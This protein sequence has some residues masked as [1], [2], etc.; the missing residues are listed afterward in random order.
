MAGTQDVDET[1]GLPK[2]VLEQ[3]KTAEAMQA[4]IL[5]NTGKETP[6]PAVAT[7]PTPAIPAEGVAPATPPVVPAQAEVAPV[8]PAAQPADT[9]EQKYKVLQ[10]KYD[11]EIMALTGQVSRQGTILQDQSEMMSGL[12]RELDRFRA[13]QVP[14]P[15]GQ[16]S[17]AG[18]EGT[19][20]VTTNIDPENYEGF[21]QEIVDLA[22][23][24]KDLREENRRLA[25]TTA[26]SAMT[27]EQ[28]AKQGMLKYLDDNVQ[29]WR[30][31][32]GDETFLTWLRQSDPLSGAVRQKLLDFALESFD[33]TRVA[34]FF[35]TFIQESGGQQPGQQVVVPPSLIPPGGPAPPAPPVQPPPVIMPDASL[36]GQQPP[37]AAGPII[38][39]EQYLLAQKDVQTGRMTGQAFEELSNRYLT[40]QLAVQK[41]AAGGIGR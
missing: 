17:G 24:V 18:F 25:S 15:G 1:A 11:K 32:N 20:P 30:V 2:K 6:A 35:Q 22:K 28:T 7:P 23:E 10:G 31:L 21:G 41:A 3:G 5:G 4:A 27:A 13:G 16:G 8:V 33:G 29:G 39:R 9:W 38:T 19:Q 34:T 12:L 14:L 37:D 26:Q 36:G 40:Q